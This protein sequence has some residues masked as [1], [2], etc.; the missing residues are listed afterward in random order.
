MLGYYKNE[1][2]TKEAIKDGW[3]YTGDFGFFNQK[4]QLT[5]SGRKKNIIVLSNGKNVYPEEIE[6]KLKEIEEIKEIVVRGIE[7][8]GYTKS[9]LA[10]IYPD[11]EKQISEQELF[12]RVKAVLSEF[13]PYK[14]IEKIVLR[15]EP[16][17]KTT[18][19]KI[20]R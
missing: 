14:R 12:E 5:I 2:A 13:P 8:D 6:E 10:E 18:T 11:E 9:L 3:F 7:E 1:E 16:F 4:G 19:K 17:V 20:K 15:D